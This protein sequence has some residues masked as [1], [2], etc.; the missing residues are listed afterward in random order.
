M[1]LRIIFFLSK[2][3]KKKISAMTVLELLVFF[4]NRTQLKRETKI[5]RSKGLK[6]LAIN[7]FIKY[8]LRS[9]GESINP[10]TTHG[11]VP[12]NSEI[13]CFYLV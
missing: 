11:L 4:Y 8:H 7:I 2:E 3:V 5:I 10:I 1:R 9:F 12:R 6:T 13:L